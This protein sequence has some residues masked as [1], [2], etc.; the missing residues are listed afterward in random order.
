MRV[1]IFKSLYGCKKQNKKDRVSKNVQYSLTFATFV[2]LKS[3]KMKLL[4]INIFG[5]EV[6]TERDLN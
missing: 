5:S 1:S 4:S 6:F 3:D 2:I